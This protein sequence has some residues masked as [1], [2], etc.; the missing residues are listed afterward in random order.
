MTRFSEI[1]PTCWVEDLDLGFCALVSAEPRAHLS[2]D[3][4]ALILLCTPAVPQVGDGRGAGGPGFSGGAPVP[5]GCWRQGGGF[6][7][8]GLGH[9]VG[10]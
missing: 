7:A 6:R 8:G 10:A 2:L 5:R 4:P 3:E 9:R 1:T